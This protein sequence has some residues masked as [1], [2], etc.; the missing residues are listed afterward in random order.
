MLNE[1]YSAVI[2]EE[3]ELSLAKVMEDLEL[4]FAVI[5]EENELAPA[6][7]LKSRLCIICNMNSPERKE[8][9]ASRGVPRL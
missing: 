7:I 3:N 8:G 5:C 6:K 2:C 1:V 4:Y 9:T